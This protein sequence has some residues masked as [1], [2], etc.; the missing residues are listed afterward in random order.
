MLHCQNI[1][2]EKANYRFNCENTRDEGDTKHLNTNT[3]HFDALTV[4]ELRD[5]I[6]PSGLE[7]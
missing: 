1:K 2:E 6:F 4:Y 7:L 5:I 3:K